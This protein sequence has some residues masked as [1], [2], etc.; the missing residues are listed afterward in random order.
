MG[1]TSCLATGTL[2]PMHPC[3]QAC[4][5]LLREH[6][7]AANIA[8][9]T[10]ATYLGYAVGPTAARWAQ[11]QATITKVDS[12]RADVLFSP[13]MAAQLL[14]YNANMCFAWYKR[15]LAPLSAEICHTARKALQKRGADRILTKAKLVG[16]PVAGLG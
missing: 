16:M 11:P 10:H 4:A 15:Q 8:L 5:A 7:K 3:I 1:L 13:S 9:A 6:L 2:T 14:L 12:R